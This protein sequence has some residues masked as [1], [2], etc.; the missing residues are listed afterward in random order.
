M[1]YNSTTGRIWKIEN[2]VD[3]KI[4]ET[5]LLEF[6]ESFYNKNI[7]ELL[8]LWQLAIDDDLDNSDITETPELNYLILNSS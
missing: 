6:D 3:C 5:S 7:Q 4:R 1:S 2:L 8:T